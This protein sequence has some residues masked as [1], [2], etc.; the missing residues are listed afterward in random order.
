MEW[1]FVLPY[2]YKF[3][4]GKLYVNE[5]EAEAIRIIFDKYVHTDMGANGLAKIPCQSR[6]QQ[7]PKT[8]RQ[9]SAV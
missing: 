7:N 1:W 4:K 8:E 6:Y 3:E 5:E 9:E 2:G